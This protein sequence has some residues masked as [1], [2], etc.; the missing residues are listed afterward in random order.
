MV[1]KRTSDFALYVP[2]DSGA[3]TRVVPTGP[4]GIAPTSPP[5]PPPPPMSIEQL[6]AT[7]NELMR[8]LIE[9]ITH[10]GGLQLHHLSVL[11]SS[12]TDF[13]ATHPG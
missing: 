3:H 6:L 13:L 1:R 4:R 9:N 5:P 10:Q 7:Q 12:Y 2:E 8:V 11:D